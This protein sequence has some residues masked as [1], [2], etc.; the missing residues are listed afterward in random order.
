M[1][2]VPKAHQLAIPVRA[3]AA[4]SAVVH[5]SSVFRCGE[6]GRGRCGRCWIKP[7]LAKMTRPTLAAARGIA[8][9]LEASETATL[10]K[11][12]DLAQFPILAAF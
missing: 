6:A 8:D 10:L 12:V 5:G 2:S 11:I 9:E 4:V 1:L 7:R 3:H